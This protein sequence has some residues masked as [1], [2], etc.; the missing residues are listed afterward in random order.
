M[1]SKKDLRKTLIDIFLES[2]RVLHDPTYI[3]GRPPDPIL[4]G[5]VKVTF[6]I[7]E[8]LVNRLQDHSD[9]SGRS[10]A[11]I[12]TEAIQE[13]LKPGPISDK[14]LDDLQAASEALVYPPKDGPVNCVHDAHVSN[15]RL[16][17]EVRRLKAERTA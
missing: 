1:S 2:E 8:M 11:D 12:V 17:A 14:E 3:D 9:R 5:M 16:I 10:V 4:K 13:D 15:L 6:Q 7:P